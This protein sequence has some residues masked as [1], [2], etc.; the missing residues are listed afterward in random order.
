MNT[1]ALHKVREL[2][3][4]DTFPKCESASLRLEKFVRIGGDDVKKA[5]IDAV[6]SKRSQA[7]PHLHPKGS[8]SFVAT[9]GGRLIVNQ[10]GGILEN[11][12]L[13]LHP[14]FNAPYIPGS[15]VKGCA[16]HAAWQAWNDADE[17]DAKLA[18]A[19]EVAEIFGF[20]TGDT[21][22]KDPKKV[23]PGRI[24]LDDYLIRQ[25]VYKA[26]DAFIGKVAFLAA[27]PEKTAR[28]VSD[29]LTPHGG[30]DWTDPVPC[31]FP[32][33]EAGCGFVFTLVP[34]AGDGKLLDKA[35]RHLQTGLVKNGIGAKTNA[36]YGHFAPTEDPV[37][38]ALTVRLRFDSPAFLR[39]VQDEGTLRI[40][41]LRGMLRWWWRWIYR[42][43]YRENDLKKLENRIWGGCDRGSSSASCISLRFGRVPKAAN[44]YSFDKEVKS[45]PFRSLPHGRMSGLSYLSYGMDERNQRRMVLDPRP[46][47]IWELLIDVIPREGLLTADKL[48]K[49]VK[50][51]I[52][53]LTSFGGIG[54][55][56]RKGFGSLG[57]DVVY[58]NDDAV[59]ADMFDAVQGLEYQQVLDDDY[60]ADYSMF[61]S[62]RGAVVLNETNVWKVLDRVGYALQNVATDYKHSELKAVLGLPRQI[63][64]PK[65]EPMRH[66]IG[67]RHQPPLHLHADS[68]EVGGRFASPL[69]VHLT[70]TGDRI[71]VTLT[72]FPSDL[73]RDY[74]TSQ[75]ILQEAIAEITQVLCESC[76]IV[77]TDGAC[78]PG[79]E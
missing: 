1:T 25:G 40:S 17:G 34:L 49:H 67:H 79:S 20:P 4:G 39:G 21:K 74:G 59:Y 35:M 69:A 38:T 7:I 78:A 64:G 58:E 29:V 66:Q 51:A 12:G 56:S 44:C 50:L 30:N 62:I 68:R 60:M 9:L 16:R 53:A 77:S 73:A 61:G 18:A 41:T 3:G 43:I 57:S 36:G 71:R 15:A 14:H 31:V 27:V 11:A 42:S 55:R 24:Y 54:A 72:A 70:K 22:P 23:E 19:K 45:A 10:A 48:F 75:T 65:K 37:T 47:D 5:E 8:V 6:V 13:C 76:H 26:T 28:I 52:W 46:D 32:A 33:V 2:L 63:H